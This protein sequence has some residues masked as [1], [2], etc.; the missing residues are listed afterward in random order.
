M[1]RFHCTTNQAFDEVVQGCADPSR[2]YGWINDDIREAYHRLHE[3]GWAHSVEVWSGEELVGGVYGVGIG[4]F[5]AG[6]SMFH[7]ATDASKAALVHLVDRLRQ[8]PSALFDVQWLTP[9]L[10]SLGAIEIPRSEYL[11]RL[12][13][14][15]SAKA[16]H[17]W[18]SPD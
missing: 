4:S 2:P 16:G 7:G 12:A 10:E 3:L 9:H 1:R 6:E 11:Q 13:V 5:F 18:E 17:S 15:T 8:F 14:A